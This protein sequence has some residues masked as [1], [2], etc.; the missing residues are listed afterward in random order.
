MKRLILAAACS[1]MTSTATAEGVPKGFV[2]YHNQTAIRHCPSEKLIRQWMQQVERGLI[3][4]QAK[5]EGCLEIPQKDMGKKA[6]AF[7]LPHDRVTYGKTDFIIHHSYILVEEGP[8]L[9]G[10]VY[11][12]LEGVRA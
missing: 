11:F 8:A 1:A 3:G 7:L 9:E 5:P 12:A 6:H 2:M 10:F 4:V